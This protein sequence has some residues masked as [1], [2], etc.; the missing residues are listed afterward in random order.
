MR[1]PS[2]Q[3]PA[4]PW[5]AILWALVGCY[6]VTVIELPGPPPPR[7]L[8]PNQPPVPVVDYAT[9][10]LLPGGTPALVSTRGPNT[11]VI[12]GCGLDGPGLWFEG[13]AAEMSAM[14]FPIDI[15][16]DDRGL[17][18]ELSHVCVV[19]VSNCAPYDQCI[20]LRNEFGVRRGEPCVKS[21][22]GSYFKFYEL[23]GAAWNAVTGTATDDIRCRLALQLTQ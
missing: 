14:Q 8:F 4:G 19:A 3:L 11:E 10:V 21:D 13:A 2:S 20:G 23:S 1:S 12:P 15:V 6:D 7:K 17:E 22:P 5:L 16:R 9:L 18:V